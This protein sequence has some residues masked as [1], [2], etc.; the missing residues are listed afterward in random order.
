[1]GSRVSMLL[2]KMATGECGHSIFCVS[3]VS[4]RAVQIPS[5][6][7]EK[8]SGEWSVTGRKMIPPGALSQHPVVAKLGYHTTITTL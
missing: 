3:F 7:V 8:G 4:I 2:F 1:M 5:E 6:S